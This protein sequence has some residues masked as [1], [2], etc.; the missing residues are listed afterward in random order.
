MVGI[1]TFF[2]LGGHIEIDKHRYLL[3]AHFGVGIK[4]RRNIENA[5]RMVI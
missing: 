2:G 5:N 1:F 3:G 4:R